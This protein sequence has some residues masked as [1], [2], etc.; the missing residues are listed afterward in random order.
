MTKQELAIASS[1]NTEFAPHLAALWLSIID[2]CKNEHVCF[3]FFVLEEDLSPVARQLL[4]NIV[5]NNEEKANIEFLSL[6]KNAIR[7]VVTSDRIPEIAYYRILIPKLLKNSNFKNVLYLDCDMIVLEDISELWSMDTS[8]C[9]VAAVED[10][11]FH[12][13]LEK[14]G[15]Q[16][17]STMYFNSGVML[18]NIAK[19]NEYGITE[20][21]LDF[22]NKYPEKLRFHDQDALNAVLYDNWHRLHPKWNVQSYILHKAK[23]HPTYSGERE[24]KEARK[25]PHIIHFTGHLK[26][27][28]AIY[29]HP[30]K[31]YYEKYRK[32]V[33]ELCKSEWQSLALAS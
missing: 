20:K 30:S 13:R 22:I 15:I 18:M 29:Q 25:K 12:Q 32:K 8:N 28:S 23:K 17:M 11:G 26:P 27:W 10:S 19:W 7:N 2:N 33:A 5:R 21:T 14:M 6:R 9:G 3:K 24:Y 16:A 31:K 4:R 1:C